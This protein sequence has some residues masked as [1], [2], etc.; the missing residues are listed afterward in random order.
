[1]FAPLHGVAEDP[2]TGSAT[3]ALGALL[4]T[5]NTGRV[6]GAGE[7]R[8]AVRQGVDMGRPAMMAVRA[9]TDNGAAQRAWIGGDCVAMMRG[10]LEV[11]P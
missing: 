7:T 11:A 8:L 6:G 3:V 1:M 5:L 4:G 2:A 9:L 10:T